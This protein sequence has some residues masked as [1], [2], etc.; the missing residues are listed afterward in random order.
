M[1]MDMEITPWELLQIIAEIP[2]TSTEDR[3]GCI[4]TDGDGW[5]DLSD[6][7]PHIP[8]QMVDSDGDGY[9]DNLSGHE[10]D[11]CP[12]VFGTSLLDR[13]GCLDLDDDGY[14]D[15]DDQWLA[16]P[17]G[18]ADAFANDPWQWLD[19]DGD[20]FGDNPVGNL[21]MIAP[22]TLEVLPLISKDVQIIME[23]DI[24]ILLEKLKPQ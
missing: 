20:G 24:Q 3:F 15:P 7:F 8:S 21:R 10:P 16:S 12:T 4:D 13:R 14:S 23:M 5:S 22:Q 18:Q 9:G 11:A 19:T 6:K 17:E 1:V 2:G